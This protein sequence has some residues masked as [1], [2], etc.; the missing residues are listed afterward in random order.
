MARRMAANTNGLTPQT[1]D[2]RRDHLKTRR[3]TA[4]AWLLRIP[5]LAAP[6]MT[7]LDVRRKLP[8]SWIQPRPGRLLIE[9]DCPIASPVECRPRERSAASRFQ[10][11]QM[12]GCPLRPC[13]PCPMRQRWKSLHVRRARKSPV[14]IASTMLLRKASYCFLV[15]YDVAILREPAFRGMPVDRARPSPSALG[16]GKRHQ[17][18]RLGYLHGSRGPLALAPVR[19]TSSRLARFQPPSIM[20]VTCPGRWLTRLV[21]HAD[22]RRDDLSQP[23][24]ARKLRPPVAF[25]SSFTIWPG[26]FFDFP[27]RHMSPRS[28]RRQLNS[29]VLKS[30]KAPTSRVG[31]RGKD[32]SRRGPRKT[33]LRHSEWPGIGDRQA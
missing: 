19:N 27:V 20:I 1:L 31:L 17:H 30:Q 16:P 11:E 28:R 4:E 12:P 13:V 14:S 6:P 32:A 15:G 22:Q 33:C 21:K 18:L 2:R 26:G 8:V 24:R 23:V 5:K 3:C 7:I 29:V 9:A 25:I 10:K